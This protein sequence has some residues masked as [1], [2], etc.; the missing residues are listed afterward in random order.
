MKPAPDVYSLNLIELI[1]RQNGSKLQ[2]LVKG[3]RR[4]GRFKIVECK[5]A[6]SVQISINSPTL[7]IGRPDSRHSVFIWINNRMVGLPV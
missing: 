5:H 2:R 6:G 3:S 4:T 1:V 7:E